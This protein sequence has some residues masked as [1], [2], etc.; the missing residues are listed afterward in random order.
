MVKVAWPTTVF[1][2]YRNKYEQSQ[3]IAKFKL[4]KIWREFTHVDYVAWTYY[5]L[6]FI[7]LTARARDMN[8]QNF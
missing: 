4:E 5:I 2:V 8:M 6:I 3:F 7:R 1:D